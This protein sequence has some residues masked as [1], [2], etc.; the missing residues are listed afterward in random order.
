MVMKRILYTLLLIILSVPA[1][2]AQRVISLATIDS[3]AHPK[4]LPG[5]DEILHFASKEINVGNLTEDDQPAT[6]HFT[7]YNASSQ[8]VT[9]TRI[10]TSCGC[11]AAH[12]SAQ[13]VAPGDQGEIA[14]TFR[15]ADQAGKVFNRAF[16]YTNL[17]DAQPTLCLALT[18]EVAPTSNRWRD[19]PHTMGE[20]RLRY[21]TVLFSEVPERLSPSERIECGNS[22]QKP[23]T[24]SVPAEALPAYVKFRTEPEVI[25]AGGTGEIVIT[26]QGSLLPRDKAQL[27]FPLLIEGPE[28]PPAQRS[29]LIKVNTQRTMNDRK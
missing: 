5:G 18:G 21:T 27:R 22:G 6:Y 7:F 23:L 25:P 24:L 26:I 8:V 17:S 29:L 15:P 16:V 2:R 4:M 1:T 12:Y 13:P 28:V 19:Y 9:I 14:L 20:L 10:K 11:T 3:I